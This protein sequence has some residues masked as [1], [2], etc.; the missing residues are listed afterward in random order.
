M[1]EVHKHT[2]LTGFSGN[3][4]PMGPGTCLDE[5]VSFMLDL[6]EHGAT[7]TVRIINDHGEVLKAEM[8]NDGLWIASGPWGKV[9]ADRMDKEQVA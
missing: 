8:E 6:E 4:G 7:G 9:F 1:Y 2:D 3:T 5:A